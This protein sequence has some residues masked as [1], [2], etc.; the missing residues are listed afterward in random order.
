MEDQI[1]TLPEE[2]G[3]NVKC[4]NKFHTALLTVGILALIF[5]VIWAAGYFLQ[6]LA[7]DVGFVDQLSA[8]FDVVKDYLNWDAIKTFFTDWNSAAWIDIGIYNCVIALIICL[9]LAII[10]ASVKKRPMVF[11][12]YICLI[13]LVYG[14][15]E[16]AYYCEATIDIINDV[17]SDWASIYNVAYLGAWLVACALSVCFW[18]IEC[19][20]AFS[21][22]VEKTCKC[23]CEEEGEEETFVSTEGVV[24]TAEDVEPE[25]VPMFLAEPEPEVESVEEPVEEPVEKPVEEAPVE[26][27]PAPEPTPV[28]AAGPTPIVV[29]APASPAPTVIVTPVPTPTPAPATD[30]SSVGNLSRDELVSLLREIVRETVRDEVARSNENEEEVTAGSVSDSST[31]SH[32]LTGASFGGPLVVQYFNG[33]VPGPHPCPDE[34]HEEPCEEGTEDPFA[35]DAPAP[36]PVVVNVYNT[37]APVAQDAVVKQVVAPTPAP[38]PQPKPTPVVAPVV[39]PSEDTNKIVRI[40]FTDR[41]LVADEETKSN[42]N[43]LKNTLLSYGLKSRI[44]NSGDTFRLHRKTYVKI[45]VAGKSLKLYFALNPEDYRES[46]IPVQDAG[47]KGVYEDI[48]LVFKVKSSL[49]LRRAIQLIADCVE[50]D[51]LEQGEVGEVDWVHEIK[52]SQ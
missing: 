26:E 37:G 47:A 36:T 11:V 33:P 22:C 5:V 45:T 51:D 44:S 30:S 7:T 48:P 18:V 42:Y 25:P 1:Q 21:P 41:I 16:M 43:V 8:Q 27:T 14:V 13:V 19:C 49:S 50:K 29:T 2:S 23:V 34:C 24:F 17:S 39:A 9:I 35:S 46:T 31:Q 32:S 20:S 52:V 40:P 15:F 4:V 12:S 10:F 3:K 28:P 38:K 6:Y